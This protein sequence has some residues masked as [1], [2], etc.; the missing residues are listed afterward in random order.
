M[1]AT[2]QTV[3]GKQT[4]V[5]AYKTGQSYSKDIF[6]LTHPGNVDTKYDLPDPKRADDPRPYGKLLDQVAA[7]LGSK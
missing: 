5:L 2:I 3:D 4:V 1:E 7:K 6:L